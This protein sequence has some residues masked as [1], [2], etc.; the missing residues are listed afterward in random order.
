MPATATDL[1]PSARPA[2]ILLPGYERYLARTASAAVSAS[3]AAVPAARVA[4]PVAVPP[5]VPA[6]DVAGELAKSWSIY[7]SEDRAAV[8]RYDAAVR[9][10]ALVAGDALPASVGTPAG[11]QARLDTLRAAA[12]AS[13]DPAEKF[14]LGAQGSALGRGNIPLPSHALSKAARDRRAAEINAELAAT[15][16]PR[17]KFT[18]AARLK[19]L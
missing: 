3:S 14:R 18:L 4:A 19:A 11:R 8:D 2:S 13:V 9:I 1:V 16:C 6:V 7:E 10:S 5:A 15:A 17:A 12:S